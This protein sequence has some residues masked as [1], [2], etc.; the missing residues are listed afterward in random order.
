MLC[1][2]AIAQTEGAFT[3]CMRAAMQVYGEIE[4]DFGYEELGEKHRV[5]FL[6]SGHLSDSCWFP[7]FG[8]VAASE[9][10]PRKTEAKKEAPR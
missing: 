7:V 10:L 6:R 1:A 3:R 2:P 8:G 4:G 9:C 5:T